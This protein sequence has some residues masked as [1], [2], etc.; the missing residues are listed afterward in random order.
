MR[1]IIRMKLDVSFFL[2]II[3][4]VCIDYLGMKNGDIPDGNIQASSEYNSHHAA[5]KGRLNVGLP[6]WH[7]AGFQRG[8]TWIQADIGYQTYVSGVITQGDG[9]L[10][11]GR[12]FVTSFKV[13]TFLTTGMTGANEVF[14][15][16]QN[17]T[18]IEFPGNVDSSTEVTTTLPE[19]VFARI[20]RII[21]LTIFR[22]HCA[23]RFEILGCK[24]D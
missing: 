19:P 22:T 5:R 4:T 3:V 12:D 11:I 9:V 18:A 13:S 7:S 17:G 16:D 1:K 14:L 6:S 21:C 10:G 24:K 23:V 15:E 20:V 2:V 8:K